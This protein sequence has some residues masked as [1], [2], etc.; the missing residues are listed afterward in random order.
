ML[1]R[2]SRVSPDTTD[3]QMKAA[4]LDHYEVAQ[5]AM[6]LHRMHDDRTIVARIA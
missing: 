3:L 1:S 5:S 2:L 6:E 4:A